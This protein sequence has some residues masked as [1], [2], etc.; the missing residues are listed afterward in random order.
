MSETT[1]Y[2]V[3][4]GQ[5][6]A[7]ASSPPI[8][9][10]KGADYALNNMGLMQAQAA[11][12]AL[13]GIECAA[14]YSSP[15]K[16]AVQTAEAIAAPHERAVQIVPRLHEVDVGEWEGLSWDEV[17]E[18]DPRRYAKIIAHGGDRPYPGGESYPEVADRGLTELSQIATNHIG[19]TV[20]VVAHRVV[21]RCVAARLMGLDM[22]RA[23]DLA[24]DNGAINLV[25]GDAQR[26]KLVTLNSVSHLANL[27]KAK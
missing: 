6:D 13:A 9:Q 10:G 2:L 17:I 21:N 27:T 11:S 18:R 8:L 5:T 25:T 26:L 7:N 15:L 14:I 20:I 23:K 12:R 16:R 3:R 4:H 1:I 19:E 22:R 24:Q